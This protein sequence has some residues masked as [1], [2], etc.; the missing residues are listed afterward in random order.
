MMIVVVMC[1]MWVFVKELGYT[2][3]CS[4]THYVRWNDHCCTRACGKSFLL[5]W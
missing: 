5:M 1:Y 3:L 2:C 4:P